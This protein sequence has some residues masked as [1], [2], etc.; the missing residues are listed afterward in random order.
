LPQAWLRERRREPYYRL[1]KRVGYRSRA[2]FKL[3]QASKRKGL[4]QRGDVVVDLGAYPGGW[5]QASRSLVGE[6]GFVLGVDLREVAPLPFPNV[7]TMVG[8]VR[9]PALP[10]LIRDRL[11]RDPDVVISDVS[12]NISGVWE[13]DHARQIELAEKSLEVAAGLLRPGG[14]FFAKAFQ[15]DM[16]KGFIDRLRRRFDEVEI[17][18]PPASRSRSA[19]VYVLASGFHG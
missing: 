2:A 7:A 18:K 8:D 1:A 5:I 19:E 15:G 17:V 4:I 6:S 11:P 16:T 3:L 9:D 12:P 13:V 14:S 10:K